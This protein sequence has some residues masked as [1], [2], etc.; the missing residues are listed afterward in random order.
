MNVHCIITQSRSLLA[1]SS[2][3]SVG[4]KIAEIFVIKEVII[5]LTSEVEETERGQAVRGERNRMRER[6]RESRVAP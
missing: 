6:E 4:W 5:M 3:S 1:R 2:T